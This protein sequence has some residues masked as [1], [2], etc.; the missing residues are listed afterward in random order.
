[1]DAQTDSYLETLSDMV[2]GRDSDT[3][4]EVCMSV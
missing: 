4:T 1:M 3:Q 2:V